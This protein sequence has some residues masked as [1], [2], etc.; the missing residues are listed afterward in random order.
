MLMDLVLP[1]LSHKESV[2]INYVCC[3]MRTKINRFS[4]KFLLCIIAVILVTGCTTLFAA[5]G[6]AG[7]IRGIQKS[8]VGVCILTV[9]NFS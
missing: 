7:N 1:K 9:S 2:N 4:V 8:T 3:K 6:K 5:E